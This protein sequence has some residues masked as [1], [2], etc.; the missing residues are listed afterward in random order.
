[1]LVLSRR[2]GESIAIGDDVTITVLDV[3]GDVV[4]IGIDAPR[5]VAVHRTEVLVQVEAS[6][7]AAA[8]PDDDVVSSLSQALRKPADEAE[9]TDEDDRA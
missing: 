7:K 3:R 4:R 1:M 6:N 5:S 9:A 8:S 2:A